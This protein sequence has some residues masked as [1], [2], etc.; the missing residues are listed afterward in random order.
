MVAIAIVNPR[1]EVSYWGLEH[2][3][4]IV[5]KQANMPVASLPLL[6]ALTPPGHEVVLFDENVEELDFERLAQF[7]IIGITG[8]SVQRFRMD[9]IIE[10]LNER[11][12]YVV[13]GGPWVTVEE[14]YFG[15]RVKSIFVGEA[16]TTW[17][18]FLLDFEKGTVQRRYEQAEKTDMSLVPTPRYDL[19][20]TSRY[21]I[22]SIQFSRGCPFQCEFC[23]IIVTFGRRP[24]IKQAEQI[25]RELDALRA[26]GV[27]LAFVVDDNLIGDKRTMKLVLEEVAQWQQR[28]GYPLAF[29]TEASLDLCEDPELMELMAQCNIQAVFIGIESPNA[30]S[31]KETKKYQNVRERGGTITD[32]VH[33]IQDYGIEVW[34]GL[35]VG[36]D[37]DTP[38]IFELQ[39]RFL[40][41][42]RVAHAMIG[43]LHAIPKTPLY[44][45][46]RDEGR[47]DP[48]ED[49][50]VFGTNVIPKQMSREEL[51][52]GYIETMR[53]AYQPENYFARLDQ[54]FIK[55]NFRFRVFQTEHFRRHAFLRMRHGMFYL[56]G[57][58]V[59]FFKLMW[60]TPDRPLRR[61]YRKQILRAVKARWRSPD[62]CFY[63]AVKTAMHYHHHRMTTDMCARPEA[64]VSSYGRVMSFENESESAG[65]PVLTQSESCT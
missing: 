23:D 25:L 54:L 56:I 42:S 29:C 63:Y 13:V 47:L 62:I 19:L 8:M 30:D 34:C 35:I 16:E 65:L 60:N 46:L 44:Q 9:E 4:R 20:K 17:P 1:F 28:N 27:R 51:H 64:F 52:R 43:L 31:L 22:G 5:G 50:L 3:Q 58:L 45:R 24:R 38:E 53:F 2:A 49:Q 40:E 12:A 37:N 33:A 7:D 61:M 32:K 21:A 10:E 14:E 41:E 11:G 59:I 6:A 15:D 39:R 36:F 18:Q 48:N 57:F 55:D 26:S